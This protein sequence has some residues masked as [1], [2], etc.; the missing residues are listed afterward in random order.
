MKIITKTNW[1]T[2]QEEPIPYNVNCF[3]NE[4]E[5]LCKQWGLSL[6]HEDGHGA[7]IVEEFSESNIQW[8]QYATIVL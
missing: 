3:L 5:E 2:G 6:S 7:F 8:V 1:D 4:Y